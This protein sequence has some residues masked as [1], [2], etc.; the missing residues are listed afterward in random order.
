MPLH[1]SF[2]ARERILGMGVGGSGKTRAWLTIAKKAEMLKSPGTFYVLD[3]DDAVERM[4]SGVNFAILANR[5]QYMRYEPAARP[6]TP[7]QWVI[8]DSRGVVEDPRLVVCVLDSWTG[9]STW[10][11]YVDFSK[12][13]AKMVLNDDWI[14]VDLYNPAWG[15]VHDFYVDNIHKTDVLSFYIAARDKKGGALDGDK[16]WSIINRMYREFVGPLARLR[17]HLF[18]TTSVKAIQSE[19]NRADA[20]D[21]RILFQ[22]TGVKP[23]GQKMTHHLTH[24]II[25]FKEFAP[26][27]YH[28]NVVKDRERP[29]TAE[30]I[31]HNDFVM[32]YLLPHAGWKLA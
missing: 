4:V 31:V 23:E 12:Q 18:I 29:K 11:Q 9:D 20:K 30:A 21:V 2:P 27:V 7:G 13:Y 24:T 32:D 6:K 8:D 25:M 14:V 19:G 15:E 17:C 10:P 28:M 3:T 1:P 5:V 16:D 26:G 22:S